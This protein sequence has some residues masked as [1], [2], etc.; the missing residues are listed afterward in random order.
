MLNVVEDADGKFVRDSGMRLSGSSGGVVFVTAGGKLL[1]KGHLHG[2]TKAG[3]DEALRDWN[4]LPE[5]ERKPGAIQLGERGPLD[6][7]RETAEPPPGGLI[8]K[9]QGR[10]LAHGDRGALRTTTLLKDFPGIKQPATAFPGHF[11]FYTEA[12]PDFAWLTRDE[13][14]ALVPTQAE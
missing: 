12:N 6:P 14:K 11:E 1:G 5:T 3:I 2:T 10:Y 8:L 4:K 9:V 13:W 7:E